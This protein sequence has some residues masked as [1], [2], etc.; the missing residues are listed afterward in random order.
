MNDADRILRGLDVAIS[1]IRVQGDAPGCGDVAGRRAQRRPGSGRPASGLPVGAA[2]PELDPG[3]DG[4]GHQQ[5]RGDQHVHGDAEHGQGHDG[6][7]SKG[8]DPG[9][10]DRSPFRS[11]GWLVRVQRKRSRRPAI[12]AAAAGWPLPSAGIS[13]QAAM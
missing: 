5:P 8:D 10:G 1:D 11:G 13:S 4:D 2:R 7:K 3:Q 6:D 9:P 12:H